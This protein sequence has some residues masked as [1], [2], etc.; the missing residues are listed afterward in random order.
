MNAFTIHPVC[1][2]RSNIFWNVG[3]K[4]RNQTKTE[5]RNK[6]EDAWLKILNKSSHGAK[7]GKHSRIE[8]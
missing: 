2:V 6:M 8:S 3:T 7:Y 5:N 4:G 1:E